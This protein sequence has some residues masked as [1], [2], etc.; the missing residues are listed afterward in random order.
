MTPAPRRPPGVSLDRFLARLPEIP[1]PDR[2]ALVELAQALLDG[3]YVHLRQKRA[4]YGID[5]VQQ[6]RVLRQRLD[7]LSSRQ[8]HDELHLILAAL[9]DRHTGYLAGPPLA[10]KA[11]VLPFLVESYRDAGG[12]S[13]YLVTRVADWAPPSS[14][15]VTGTELTHWN[16]VP[17]QRA[18]ERNAVNQRGAHDDARLARG[19]VTLTTRSL[20]Y[21]S[22][23]EEHWVSVALRAGREVVETRVH[24]R[25]IDAPDPVAA[26]AEAGRGA[27][28][29]A[30]RRADDP[31]GQ[32]IQTA[33]RRLYAPTRAKAPW[34]QT[35][36]PAILAAR[37]LPTRAGTLGYLRIWS[38]AHA[39]DGAVRD[40]AQRL[41]AQL[42]PSGLIVDVRGNPG[43]NIPTAERL[44]QVL[45]TRPITPAQFSLTN[46]DQTLAM[47]REDS[48][49]LGRWTASIVEAV[50]TGELYAQ[51]LPLTDA[52][53]AN[54]LKAERRYPGPV[55]LVIDALTY[56]AADIFAAGFQDNQ[57]GSILGTDRA[58]GA[59]GANVW[60]A[61][62]IGQ[63]L[64]SVPGFPVQPAGGASFTVALRRA[65]RVNA[66]QGSPLEDIGVKPDRV[67]R[68]TRTD[69][70]HANHDLLEAAANLLTSSNP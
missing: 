48:D 55:V 37:P 20:Q 60:T 27:D 9:R 23:P 47:C 30:L 8:F 57:L 41:V 51:G 53:R 21:A 29:A 59:G 25:V 26:A 38:F 39:D 18:V 61:A 24:W 1:L 7:E 32:A 5:P 43:G 56:S 16:G 58:S 66:R 45:T 28:E 17:I 63:R 54:D 22:P 11:A 14:R 42:P 35:R 31:A 44:L 33:R 34:L 46:T 19:L 65:T 6:L 62:Q 40:E 68:L 70:L 15:L 13:R 50:G 64:G 12:T 4:R 69:L 2:A 36:L 49:E 52:E 10:G 67:H 3:V